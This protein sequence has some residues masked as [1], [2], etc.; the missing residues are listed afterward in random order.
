MAKDS[1][2]QLITWR[3]MLIAIVLMPANSYFAMQRGLEWSGPPG[4]ISLLYNVVFTILILIIVNALIRKILPRKALTQ[5]ELITIYV[6]LCISTSL[7]G[8]DVIQ[9]IAPILGYVFFYATP[10]NEWQSLFW[11]R[12]PDWLTVRD[13][14]A[15]KDLFEGESSAYDPSNYTPWI[16]PVLWWSLL[17]VMIVFTG[18]CI[19]LIVRKQWTENER[20]AYPIIQLPYEMTIRGG[21]SGF[22]RNNLLWI[23]FGIAAGIDIIN[24]LH[25]FF[26]LVPLIP[27]RTINI[28]SFFTEKP[29]NG[30]GW[31]PLC[32]FPFIIGLGFLMPLD[33]SLSIWIFYL[34]WKAERI[35]S[36]AMGWQKFIDT[37]YSSTQPVGAFVALC[38]IALYSARQH[39]WKVLK[40]A[41]GSKQ[42]DADEPISHSA[43][44]WGATIGFTLIVLFWMRAGVSLWVAVLLF[45]IYFVFILFGTRLRAEVGAPAIALYRPT[46]ALVDIMGTRRIGTN[47][48]AIFAL[49]GGINR[50][51]RSHPM[52]HELEGFKLAERAGIKN[53]KRLFFA[54]IIAA[55]L[56]APIGFWAYMDVCYRRGHP[57]WFGWESYNLAQ[58]WMYKLQGTDVP[59]VIMMIGGGILTVLLMAARMRF[60]WWKLHPLGFAMSMNWTTEWAWFPIFM[61]WCAKSVI[62][63]YGGIKGYRRAT[64]FFLGL[65]LGDFTIGCI[66]N[67]MG[68]FMKERIYVF[69]H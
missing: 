28:G 56:A 22:F 36:S 17:L 55:I 40:G 1:K 47:N 46:K 26:P 27:I 64:Y 29:W 67:I 63:K 5:A 50:S 9:V 25:H 16:E 60:L 35:L 43:A 7:A 23:G 37:S 3:A 68:L 33:L 2:S 4:T 41:Y 18:L 11:D 52:P 61:S 48:L 59:A 62:L 38:L 39:L 65:I 10:E 21:A 69:W 51:F 24:G 49:L 34:V 8:H 44:F 15:L 14:Y 20:L 53:Q 19:S 57:G 32:F 58:S 66:L 13:K 45:I 31:T 6:M 12:I 42:N 54:I 30:M